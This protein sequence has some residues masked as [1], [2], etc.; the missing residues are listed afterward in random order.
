MDLVVNIISVATATTA[1]EFVT[2][3]I[4]TTIT[5]YQNSK[6]I[7]WLN[8]INRI[9]R[10]RRLMGFF[11]ATSP[12]VIGQVFSTTT[13]YALY[14]HFEDNTSIPM[15]VPFHKIFSGLLSGVSSSIFTHPLDVVKTQKQM[16]ANIRWQMDHVELL[17]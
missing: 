7:S 2:L 10:T 15:I 5:N 8:T 13:K 14:R 4:C 1:A 6:D 12:A 3:P 16:G 17:W 9:Y 11:S